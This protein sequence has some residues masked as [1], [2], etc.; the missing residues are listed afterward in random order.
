M[1]KLLTGTLGQIKFWAILAG[2]I[3]MSVLGT[4]WI[5]YALDLIGLYHNA[6]VVGGSVFFF[7]AVFWW[8]WSIYKITELVVLLEKSSNTFVEVKT[9]IKQIR[10]DIKIFK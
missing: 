6:L 8:W 5:A 7:V 2:T 9:E 10:E 4:L 3:P 1:I